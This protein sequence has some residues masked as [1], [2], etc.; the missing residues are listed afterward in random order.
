MFRQNPQLPRKQSPEMQHN[1]RNHFPEML[2]EL[3]A[4]A[5]CVRSIR[6]ERACLHAIADIRRCLKR[7]RRRRT[8]WTHQR[9]LLMLLAGNQHANQSCELQVHYLHHTPAQDSVKIVHRNRNRFST[10]LELCRLERWE[11]LVSHVTVD[12]CD[13]ANEKSHPRAI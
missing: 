13:R 6:Q 1:L 8:A 7:A 2:A 9:V 3:R 5:F 10:E 4:P 11:R 12:A